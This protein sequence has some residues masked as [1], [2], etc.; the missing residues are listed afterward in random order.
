M[1]LFL[2]PPP[3]GFMGMKLF[4]SPP[5]AGFMGM[6]LFLSPPPAGF[7]AAGVKLLVLPPVGFAGGR[8]KHSASSSPSSESAPT[9]WNAVPRTSD[10]ICSTV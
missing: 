5:P 6:K 9:P 8:E 10:R 3:A 2:S 7:A 4:L 1:K